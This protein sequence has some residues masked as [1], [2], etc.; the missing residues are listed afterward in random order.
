MKVKVVKPKKVPKAKKLLNKL[1]KVKTDNAVKVSLTKK[2][3]VDMKKA[4]KKYKMNLLRNRP[5]EYQLKN[6]NSDTK[7]SFYKK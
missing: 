6:L 2:E 1:K 7:L 4:I 3:V 5:I